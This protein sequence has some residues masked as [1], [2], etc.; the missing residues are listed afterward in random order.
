MSCWHSPD[1]QQTRT[2]F[3]PWMR[4]FALNVWDT[5]RSGCKL[6]FKPSTDADSIIDDSADD[7]Q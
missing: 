1:E 6:S 3:V 2:V 4:D 7:L 5:V